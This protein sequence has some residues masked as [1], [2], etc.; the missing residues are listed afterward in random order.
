MEL[1]IQPH[2]RKALEIMLSHKN[3]LLYGG[4]RS[5]KSFIITYLMLWIANSYD[6][7]RAIS[8][9]TRYLVKE[10][11]RQLIVRLTY[12]DVH[13]SII[14]ETLPKVAN[15]MGIEYK[16]NQKDKYIRLP[17]GSEIWYAAL[18]DRKGLE[19]ALGKEY[20]TIWFNEVSQITYN[21]FWFILSRLAQKSG[22][23]NRA[24]VSPTQWNSPGLPLTLKQS[25]GWIGYDKNRKRN[26]FDENLINLSNRIFCDENPPSKAHWSYK[27]FIEGIDPEE[28]TVLPN[29]TDY[30]FIQMNPEENIRYISDDYIKMYEN[31]PEKLRK[32]FLKGEFAD[33]LAGSLFTETNINQFRVI[34]RPELKKVIITVDPAITSKLTSDETGLIVLAE[35]IDGDGYVLQDASG[36]YTPAEWAKKVALLYKHWDA[37]YIVAEKNQGGDMVKHTIQ[38]ENKNLPVKLVSATK[39]KLLRAEPIS[40]LYSDGRIHH[41]G[42]FPDLECEMTTYTGA[43]TDKSP[44]RL[45]ALVH[46]F[47]ELFPAG[48]SEENDLFG[49][50]KLKYYDLKTFT[51][52]S[53]VF[54][55]IFDPKFYYFGLIVCYI[56]NSR[57]FISQV[58]FNQKLPMDNMPEVINI[59]SQTNAE[60]CIVEC[61]KSYTDFTR[62][63]RDN[64]NCDVR[65]A[66]PTIEE[67]RIII[68]SQFIKDN[69]IFQ[70][71]PMDEQ[72]KT[73]LRHLN[74]Y[75]N[76]SDHE[77]S[78]AADLCASASSLIKKIEDL[79]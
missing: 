24:L 67:N 65:G 37:S 54:I 73:F 34:R 63:L 74:N 76:I 10:P 20:T 79:G 30:D 59:L 4:G 75:T 61:D 51:G 26:L 23:T 69:F 15:M 16:L 27:L 8:D 41:V 57:I 22:F 13:K 40:F 47:S 31:A 64:T 38:S 77:E 5:G 56:E 32:R 68:E 66:K 21:S 42:A 60:T 18:D 19:G 29:A 1:K 78:H 6:P 62:T 55:K 50:E 25:M 71:M 28:R 2:Q 46:G 58:L 39:G 36:I 44:N 52:Q 17:N 48:I 3:S 33:E 7:Q 43:T 72:Y 49:V 9:P 53:F 12:A 14:L 35:G 70:K 11:I 45:D